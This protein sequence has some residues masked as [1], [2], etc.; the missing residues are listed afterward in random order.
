MKSS[1]KAAV[2]GY[3]LLIAAWTLGSAP[4]S[5]PD[6]WAHYLRAL[7]MAH[8]ELIGAPVA[9][10]NPQLDPRQEAWVAQSARSIMVQPGMAPDGYGCNAFHPDVSA[11]CVEKIVPPAAAVSRVVVNGTYQPAAY[12]L[13]ALFLKAA[14]RPVPALL[15]ARL[16]SALICIALIA[17]AAAA[18]APSLSPGFHLALTPMALFLAAT[19]NPSGPE[20]AAAL[21]FTAGMLALA[22]ETGGGGRATWAAIAVGGSMLCLSRSLGP[23]W[24]LLIAAVWL[25]WRGLDAA[26][27][28][29]RSAPRAAAI[30]AALIGAAAVLNR[31][32]EIRYGPK[33]SFPRTEP[34]LVALR[35]S[36]KALGTW[37]WQMIG[38]FQYTDSPMPVFAYV[39]WC[40]ALVALVVCAAWKGSLRDRLALLLAAIIAVATPVL[41]HAFVL[42]PIG[43]AV[44]GR[45]VLPVAILLPLL[46]GEIAAARLSQRL[47]AAIV[48]VC[49]AVQFVGLYA[50]GHRSAVGINGS[51][52]FPLK[53]EWTPSAGWSI[54]LLLALSG[55]GLIVAATFS[56]T[57]SWMSP[58]R[59]GT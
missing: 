29:V 28:A 35:V 20:V 22:R 39:L 40:A 45:H 44:Q 37:L 6:E 19:L 46:A 34:A 32:W 51:W 58:K 16:A 21:A 41:L 9:Y 26:M 52:L 4:F 27:A 54:V 31:L 42:R 50:D 3:A 33:L 18:L 30:T 56:Q 25:W 53:P 24:V 14:S 59:N 13:P 55:A 49:A 38:V 15:L 47:W 7:G 8:G 17:L 57:K 43:W 23:L 1:G 36:V 5:S 48:A 10:S 12:L 11:A 2:A